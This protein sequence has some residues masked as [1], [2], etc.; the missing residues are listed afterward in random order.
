MT[1]P[2][3]ERSP[4]RREPTGEPVV[5]GDP[6]IAGSRAAAA[7]EF[8]PADPGSLETATEIVRD[9]ARQ[10]DE[11][12]Q[13]DILRGAAACATLVRGEASYRAAAEQA[14]TD[15]SINFLRKWARVH[16]LP[17]EIRRHIALGE[18]VPSAAQHVAR[19]E[20]TERYLLAWAIIDHELSVREVRSVVSD[21]RDGAEL[22]TA[23]ARFDAVPG[24]TELVLPVDLYH[25]VRLEAATQVRDVD[26]LLAEAVRDWLADSDTDSP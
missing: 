2:D 1:D 4:S 25:E 16:D 23:L 15:V 22:K 26:E 24:R 10:V 9:F 14:G 3:R 11:F 13:F 19:L 18:I 5:R 8:D 7:I 6:A 17:I 20:G 12:S 21:V